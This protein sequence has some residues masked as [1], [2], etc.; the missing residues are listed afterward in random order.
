MRSIK[1]AA[2]LL[3]ALGPIVYCAGLAWHFFDVGG[4]VEGVKMLGLGPTVVGLGGIGLLFGVALIFKVLRIIN[5][6]PH[7]PGSRFGRDDDDGDNG[8]DPDAA[9]ARYL[10][11]RTAEPP[12]PSPARPSGF[13]RRGAAKPTGFGRRA[14]DR[15]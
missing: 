6:P 7:T 13:E 4:S 15:P 12:A 5:D 1:T 14:T 10:S 8:F 9:I 2:T 3:G 11:Q